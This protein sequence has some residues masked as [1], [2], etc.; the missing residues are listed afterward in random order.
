[1]LA[2]R[3]L[4]RS[5]LVL[6]SL[7]A[8]ACD[9]PAPPVPQPNPLRGFTASL[10]IHSDDYA[11][12]GLV[13]E[14]GLKPGFPVNEVFALQDLGGTPGGRSHNFR[15]YLDKS[16]QSDLAFD[17]WVW[18]SEKE[19]REQFLKL[20]GDSS[21][22]AA[23]VRS[24]LGDDSAVQGGRRTDMTWVVVVFRSGRFVYR[25]D[26][27]WKDSDPRV[28]EKKQTVVEKLAPLIRKRLET[29]R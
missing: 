24:L 21:A 28:G 11:S 17:L 22:T 2:Q 25:S 15:Y 10:L 6:V 20:A 14:L 1:M 4:A 23:N 19:A 26:N 12:L 29:L 8:A 18:D 3:T 7:L 16:H 27:S 13:E 5:A 9:R